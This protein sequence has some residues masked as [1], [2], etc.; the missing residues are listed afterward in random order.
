M[1][2]CFSTPSEPPPPFHTDSSRH[3]KTLSPNYPNFPYP[4]DPYSPG[5]PVSTLGSKNDEERRRLA[6]QNAKV[7]Q[8]RK[9]NGKNEALWSFMGP[10]LTYLI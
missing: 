3:P 2:L 8:E 5:Q 6:K 10:G 1:G 9:W 7:A 4:S